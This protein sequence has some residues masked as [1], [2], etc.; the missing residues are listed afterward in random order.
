MIPIGD[1]IM[2]SEYNLAEMFE[3]LRKLAKQQAWADNPDYLVVECAGGNIDDAYV[4]GCRDGEIF[5]ARAL[6]DILGEE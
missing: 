4:G 3:K 2:L 1:K 5:L 6:L